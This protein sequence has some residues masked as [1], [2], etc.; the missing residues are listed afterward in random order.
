MELVLD[1][2]LSF[3]APRCFRAASHDVVMTHPD[4]GVVVL[5]F[6]QCVCFPDG[7]AKALLSATL[8]S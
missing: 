6:E 1:Y 2:L 4:V 5:T 3:W 8:A 7:P